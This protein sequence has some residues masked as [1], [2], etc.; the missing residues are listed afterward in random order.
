MTRYSIILTSDC[1]DDE[2]LKWCLDRLLWGYPHLVDSVFSEYADV[3]TRDL[4]QRL[5]KQDNQEVALA[6]SEKAVPPLLPLVSPAEL[7]AHAGAED[8]NPAY[9]K[10]G[11]G[12]YALFNP[13]LERSLDVSLVHS[14]RNDRYVSF[15]SSTSCASKLC[16]SCM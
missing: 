16:S 13:D 10:V 7:W 1:R 5:E 14:F 4:E 6:K 8:V 11:P 15:T 2:Y 9:I 3:R 12:W